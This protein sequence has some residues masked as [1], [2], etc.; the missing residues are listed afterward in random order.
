MVPLPF[1]GRR[2]VAWAAAGAVFVATASLAATPLTG[3]WAKMNEPMAPFHV[4]GPIYDVGMQGLD[5]FL[6]RTPKGSI[7]VDGGFEQ[8]VPQIEANI[9]KL[10]VSIHDVHYI[11]NEHAHIDHAGGIAKLQ[12]D[13]GARIVAGVG[14]VHDLARGEV[15]Y[16]PSAGDR[17]PGVRVD[18]PVREGQTLALGGLT[19]T[20]HATSGH[21]KGCTSWTLP[22]VENGQAHTAFF[23][24]SI[25]VA[26][27]PIG[28][29]PTYPTIGDD[30][31]ATF[32]KLRTIKADVVL[33]PHPTA[34]DRDAKR[35]RAGNGPNPFVD[36]TE[37]RRLVDAS[38]RDFDVQL[39]KQKAAKK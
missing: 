28:G 34:W 19:L 23:G 3:D 1:Q 29:T 4:I 33:G 14:D 12:R 27:N 5:V 16:G 39:A 36:P 8:S 10:G 18:I 11:L 37:L 26:G 25:T 20:A 6:I 7:L 35:T 2:R 9:R 30:Y 24:C 17:Y 38:E 13:S 15:D 21:T 31:R 32:A 22:F